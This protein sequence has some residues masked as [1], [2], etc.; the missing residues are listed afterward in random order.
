M[1]AMAE[2]ESVQPPGTIAEEIEPGYRF[3]DKILRASRVIVS[4]S[5]KRQAT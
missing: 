3:Y 2:V 4:K 5:D 1:E